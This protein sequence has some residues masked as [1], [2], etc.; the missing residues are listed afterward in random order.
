[1]V[2][3]ESV[4][5]SEDPAEALC[6]HVAWLVDV[7]S[8]PVRRVRMHTGDISLELEWADAPSR[9]GPPEAEVADD[10]PDGA[11]YVCAP[12]VGTFYRASGEDAQPF[13]DVGDEIQ[14]GQQLAIIEA[15]KL[16][17]PVTAEL[18]GRVTQVL[19][20]NATPVEYAQP[21]FAV[22][23]VDAVVR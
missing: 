8:G 10:E 23:P 2:S 11:D 14:P 16:M 7:V 1:M 19:V 6:R 9:A 5:R 22:A 3:S 12:L 21:L 13:V 4:P 15:M 20:A 18:A 17:N